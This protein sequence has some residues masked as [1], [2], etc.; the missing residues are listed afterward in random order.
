MKIVLTGGGSGGHFYPLI[1]VAEELKLLAEQKSIL[2]MEL[3]YFAHTPYDEKALF[4]NQIK[5]SQVPA[6]KIRRYF[7]LE[8][9]TDVF[10]TFF[11]FFIALYK[12]FVLYPDVVFSKGGFSAVPVVLAAKVLRIPIIVHESDTI[13]GRATKLTAKYADRVAISF[14]E[15]FQYFDSK[16]V[17]LV[18]H[19]VRRELQKPIHEGAYEYLKLN[20]TIP[21]IFIMGGSQ[22][23][24]IINET[25]L[26]ALPLLVEKYQVIHQTGVKNFEEIK[27]QAEVILEKKQD[28]KE[29]YHPFPY[30][31]P[32]ALR[33]C[34][35]VANL[36]VSRAGASSIAEI[37]WWGVPSIVIPISDSNGDHQRK[38]AFSYSATGAASVIEEK[39]LTPQI[40]LQEIAR[41]IDDEKLQS[42]M[43]KATELSRYENATK[44]IASELI[45]IGFKHEN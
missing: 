14:K 42:N 4:D 41:I 32:L 18:G 20:P 13:P 38:N 43:K 37:A 21:T 23:A 2:Q 9:I 34:A 8:N 45:S 1:A 7:S 15:A 26:S 39:N 22:G 27:I 35:G 40:F 29:H 24:K 10:K 31:N 17:A 30:L 19:L 16:K 12:L 25:I 28:L 6:G 11:G 44:T 33:M 5:F 3:H 36:V